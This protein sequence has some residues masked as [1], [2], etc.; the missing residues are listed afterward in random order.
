ME[1]CPQ[2]MAGTFRRTKSA[3]NRP[4]GRISTLTTNALATHPHPLEIVQL[5]R[6]VFVGL[7]AGFAEPVNCLCG[8]SEDD[9]AGFGSGSMD[10]A[11][12]VLTQTTV[13]FNGN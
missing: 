11:A 1:F 4:H 2:N 10:A 12:V 9:Q 8:L 13:L 7:C 5:L 6:A 3:E